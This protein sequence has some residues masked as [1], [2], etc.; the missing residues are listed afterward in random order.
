[1]FITS[2]LET[3][4]FNYGLSHL[5]IGTSTHKLRILDVNIRNLCVEIPTLRHKL[6]IFTSNIR[7]LCVEVLTLM[8]ESP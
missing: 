6:R 1:M 2:I 8:Y 4:I 7:K 5:K 3:S